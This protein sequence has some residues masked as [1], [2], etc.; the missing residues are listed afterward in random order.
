MPGGKTLQPLELQGRRSMTCCGKPHPPRLTLELAWSQLPALR[1][2]MET[3]C[4]DATD[5]PANLGNRELA[6]L[7]T[8]F[9][10]STNASRS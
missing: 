3:E 5:M 7:D 10:K 8:D 2:C 9:E 6:W 1:H 4:R